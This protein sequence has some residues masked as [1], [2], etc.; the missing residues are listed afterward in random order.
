MKNKILS[1]A[2]TLILLSSAI[3][4]FN[5]DKASAHKAKNHKPM[6]CIPEEDRTE[7][8][9]N[10]CKLLLQGHRLCKLEQDCVI[11]ELEKKQKEVEEKQKEVEELEDKLGGI[12]ECGDIPF[13]HKA[14]KNAKVYQK[15]D[16][17]S[18]V[19][20]K[21][22]KG[23]ELL[24][25][26]ASTKDE[27]WYYVKVKKESSC[28]DGY[29]KAKYVVKKEEATDDVEVKVKKSDLIKILKPKLQKNGK[30]MVIDAEGTLSIT[31]A[32]TEDKI[33]EILINEE[34]EVIND[35]NTFTYL[36]FVPSEG[37]E[38]RIIGKNN[39]E[40]VKELSFK[41]KVGK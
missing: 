26:A 3:I 35:D 15:A 5:T 10:W 33:D 14:A 21:I 28:A 32:V 27:S 36:L 19:I 41:I 39:G 37:A 16:T 23:D 18:D 13:N 34:E 40:V 12:A 11:L 31:G 30:L 9:K 29:I 17:K 22:K 1:L 24:F 6:I 2:I 20:V 8:Q 7:G 4:I 25:Y 38:I